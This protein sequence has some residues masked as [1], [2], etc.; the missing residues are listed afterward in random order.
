[1]ISIL[2]EEILIKIKLRNEMITIL[3]KGSIRSKG[4]LKGSKVITR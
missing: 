3:N 1:M 2:L 4:Y